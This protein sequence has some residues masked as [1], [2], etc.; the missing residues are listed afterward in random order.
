MELTSIQISTIFILILSCP[1]SSLPTLA[2]PELSWEIVFGKQ[3][4]SDNLL[5]ELLLFFGFCKIME[6]FLD[7]F[8]VGKFEIDL[9]IVLNILWKYFYLP[10]QR[11]THPWSV[12][13]TLILTRASS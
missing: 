5:K 13:H 9:R 3:M 4:L 8:Y 2:N 11:Y 7:F 10:W 6:T 1:G 12:S